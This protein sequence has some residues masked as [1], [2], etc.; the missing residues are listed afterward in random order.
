MKVI[1]AQLSPQRNAQTSYAEAQAE[2]RMA[3][4]NK[5]PVSFFMP[6][7]FHLIKNTMFLP[8]Q[9]CRQAFQPLAKEALVHLIAI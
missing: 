1:I 3:N 6:I 5:I 4:P 2:A 8:F 9:A 7:S